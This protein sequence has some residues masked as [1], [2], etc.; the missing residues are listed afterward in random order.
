[1]IRLWCEGSGIPLDVLE[2]PVVA[3]AVKERDGGGAL[4]SVLQAASR[5]GIQAPPLLDQLKFA[6][7]VEKQPEAQGY[8]PV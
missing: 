4:Q 6:E 1:M 8:P 2:D 3:Q 5:M 7:I